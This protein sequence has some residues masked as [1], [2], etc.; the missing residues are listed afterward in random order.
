MRVRDYSQAAC[1]GRWEIFDES[2]YEDGY[3]PYGA[4]AKAVCAK[5]PLIREC[6]EDNSNLEGV[7]VAGLTPAERQ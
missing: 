6:R 5:C 3:F 4:E 7:I 1:V 2:D